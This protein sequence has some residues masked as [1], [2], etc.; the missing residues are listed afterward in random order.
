[1]VATIKI[2]LIGKKKE[3]KKQTEEQKTPKNPHFCIKK[4]QKH[5]TPWR[6]L[7][8]NA[9]KITLSPLKL[10]SSEARPIE[11]VLLQN[12]LLHKSCIIS[13]VM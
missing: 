4:P 3:K 9:I 8:I 6:K 13:S 7:E 1:M 11:V 12:N 10:F 5:E 2:N